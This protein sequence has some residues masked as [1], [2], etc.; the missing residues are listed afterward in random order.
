MFNYVNDKVDT[1][2]SVTMIFADD[3]SLAVKSNDF[4]TIKENLNQT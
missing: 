1:L 3:S 4:Y 2:F